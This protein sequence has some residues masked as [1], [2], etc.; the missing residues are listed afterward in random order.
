MRF[1]C[2]HKY[3]HDNV[4]DAEMLQLTCDVVHY[5][6]YR[7]DD[8]LFVANEMNSFFRLSQNILMQTGLIH[9]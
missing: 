2:F 3:H 9:L 5:P 8:Y 4:Y 7:L 1:L 6:I